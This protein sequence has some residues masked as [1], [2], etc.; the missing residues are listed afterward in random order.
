MAAAA[1]LIAREWDAEALQLLQPSVDATP[2]GP[3]DDAADMFRGAYLFEHRHQAERVLVAVA[4]VPCAHGVRLIV[5]GLRSLG[6]R[7]TAAP[8]CASLDRLG[9]E[10]FHAQVLAMCTRHPH[11][12]A[13]VQR[14]G[15][16]RTG[17]VAVKP[18]GL[19]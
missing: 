8:L 15:W 1:S 7:F 16:T 11:V 6:D 9:R 13:A 10:V 19:Q 14:N 3:L 4:P 2:W 5:S 18:L 17:G 12:M